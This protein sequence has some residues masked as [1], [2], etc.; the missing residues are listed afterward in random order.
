MYS[1]LSNSKK[2]GFPLNLDAFIC[3]L[4][5]IACNLSPDHGCYTLSP[6]AGEHV[7]GAPFSV[8]MLDESAWSQAANWQTCQVISPAVGNRPVRIP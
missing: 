4:N 2:S 6:S 7:G 3:L 1:S 8:S 5:I